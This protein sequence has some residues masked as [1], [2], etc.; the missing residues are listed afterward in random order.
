LQTQEIKKINFYSLIK[1]INFS[2]NKIKP[3]TNHQLIK[4]SKELNIPY[5]RDVFMRDNLPR[6]VNHM[7]TGIVNLDDFVNKGSHWTAYYY[8]KPKKL[9]FYFDSFGNLPPPIELNNYLGCG[10]KYNTLQ[11]QNFNENSC[12]YLCLL[13]LVYITQNY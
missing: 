4:H 1:D 5:F 9:K 3:L 8:N 6:V 13:W 10:I 12:G 7:E 2:S 11:Y